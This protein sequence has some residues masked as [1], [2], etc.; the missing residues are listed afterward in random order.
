MVKI[1]R[2]VKKEV[3]IFRD[4]S[5][6]DPWE[7]ICSLYTN[8]LTTG[9]KAKTHEKISIR[10]QRRLTTNTIQ[11]Y[12]PGSHLTTYCDWIVIVRTSIG[13][14]ITSSVKTVRLGIPWENEFKKTNVTKYYYAYSINRKT[15]TVVD[16]YAA[17]ISCQDKLLV[18][19]YMMHI[20][21]T[22]YPWIT[23]LSADNQYKLKLLWFL[24]F[25]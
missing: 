5:G 14:L 22:A 12:P 18:T 20:Y 23:S 6:T 9:D 19:D 3:S 8:V 21:M 7:R 13:D 16:W 15:R 4:V 10:T 17:I 11:D 2:S 24:M 25:P 1:P